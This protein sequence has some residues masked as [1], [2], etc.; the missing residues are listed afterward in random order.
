[1]AYAKDTKVPVDRSKAELE[2]MLAK[3][4]A[5]SFLSGTNEEHSMV[6]FEIAGRRIKFILPRNVADGKSRRDP[7]QIHRA[8]WRALV[9]CVRAKLESIESGIETIDEAFLPHV[10]M[11]NGKTIGSVVIP[12]MRQAIESGRLLPLVEG[13]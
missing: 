1:M 5:T 7:E 6:A 10:V 12:H 11:N 13:R 2:K 3:N 4:G 8:R 9:L